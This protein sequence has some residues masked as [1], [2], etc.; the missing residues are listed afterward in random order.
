MIVDAQ[1]IQADY[2]DELKKLRAMY[3]K[4]CRAAGADFVEI[5]TSMRFDKAL[6]EYLSQRRARF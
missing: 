1:G 6:V 5:D 3:R 4:E 2:L